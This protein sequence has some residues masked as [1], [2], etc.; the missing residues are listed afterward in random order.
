MDPKIPF[1]KTKL[2]DY[3]EYRKE[4]SCE[5]NLASA[6]NE[7]IS[8]HKN[9]R[10]LKNKIDKIYDK[11]NSKLNADDMHYFSTLSE[12]ESFLKVGLELTNNKIDEIIKHETEHIKKTNELG[13]LIKN[14]SCI[15]LQTK[16]NTLTYAIQTHIR[17][18]KIIPTTD[19]VAIAS[20]PNTPSEL[21]R[22]HF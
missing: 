14:F 9:Y 7:A 16:E 8:S 15:L 22:Y 18:N 11:Y 20:A 5:V 12:L 13:Y 17:V 3:I 10:N 2:E 21:D 19:L 4:V 6:R 1:P